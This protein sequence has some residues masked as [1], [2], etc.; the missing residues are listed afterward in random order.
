MERNWE[1]E[2]II[3]WNE[4]IIIISHV[5]IKIWH[6]FLINSVKR[7]RNVQ[8]SWSNII[9]CW[10]S[11]LQLNHS[12]WLITYQYMVFG[13]AIRPAHLNLQCQCL[14]ASGIG[15]QMLGEACNGGNSVSTE[16]VLL[17]VPIRIQGCLPSEGI[18]TYLIC[19][20]PLSDSMQQ[21]MHDLRC[22]DTSWSRNRNK[23]KI[24]MNVNHNPYKKDESKS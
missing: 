4:I 16:I 11:I 2:I 5:G 7:K 10:W 3:I 13:G 24:E 23:S 8:V 17:L 18:G 12:S 22:L 15:F 20:H 21:S 9:S 14:A 6:V 19:L 1:E